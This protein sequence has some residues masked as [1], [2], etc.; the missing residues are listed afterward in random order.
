MTPLQLV[1][2]LVIFLAWSVYYTSKVVIR[3]VSV[4]DSKGIR[5]YHDLVINLLFI[6][7]VVYWFLSLLVAE[8]FVY[9]SVAEFW[10]LG[11]VLPFAFL[12][13]Q[14]EEIGINNMN[15]SLHNELPPEETYIDNSVY[16][17]QPYHALHFLHA[18]RTPR[19]P[20]ILDN[21]QNIN[22]GYNQHSV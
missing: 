6:H 2:F 10:A 13:Y 4:L 14:G 21:P 17:R 18:P 20:R 5:D 8:L 1:L 11:S 9:T 3:D 22:R 12:L 19:T 16:Y 7:A 15:R